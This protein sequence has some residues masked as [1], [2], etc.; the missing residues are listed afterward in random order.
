M[1]SKGMTGILVKVM[2][3][4]RKIIAV[5]SALQFLIGVPK[6]SIPI[7]SINAHTPETPPKTTSKLHS[8]TLPSI[9]TTAP[10]DKPPVKTQGSICPMEV[11]PTTIKKYTLI[12]KHPTIKSMTKGGLV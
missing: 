6:I 3:I 4:K 12:L 2:I 11:T 5:S 8:V 9:S 7:E 10:S 1:P